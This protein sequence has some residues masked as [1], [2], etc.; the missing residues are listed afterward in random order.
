MCSGRK[1][2]FG[3]STWDH[4]AESYSGAIALHVGEGTQDLR[5]RREKPASRSVCQT[6]RSDTTVAARLCHPRSTSVERRA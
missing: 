4:L 5:G 1:M 2:L 6:E 3:N